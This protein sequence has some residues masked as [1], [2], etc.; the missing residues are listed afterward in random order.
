[1]PRRRKYA[2]VITHWEALVAALETNA[3][4]LPHLDDARTLLKTQLEEVRT[5]ISR[6]DFHTASKQQASKDL[7]EAVQQGSKV[8]TFLHAGLRHHYG[9]RNEKL[10]EFGLQPLRTVRRSTTETPVS[11][12]AQEDE[13]AET[14]E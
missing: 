2:E 5:L 4:D 11:K 7:V 9:H 6:Q 1:M 3:A 13:G 12:Q 10:V 8:T 14:K